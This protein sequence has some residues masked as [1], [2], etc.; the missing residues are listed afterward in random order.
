MRRCPRVRAGRLNDPVNQWYCVTSE[1]DNQMFWRWD[2]GNNRYWIV[3]SKTGLCL[4]VAPGG[5]N[6]RLTLWHCSLA[7]DHIWIVRG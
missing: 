6:A 4:D 7:D 3:H 2:Y 1:V 5:A